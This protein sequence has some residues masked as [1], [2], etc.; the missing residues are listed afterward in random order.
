LDGFV[1]VDGRT[2]HACACT[3]LD[4]RGTFISAWG[5]RCS[6]GVCRSGATIPLGPMW[7]R[8]AAPQYR[9]ASSG[10]DLNGQWMTTTGQNKGGSGGATRV[11]VGPLHRI[12]HAAAP[13]SEGR[14][15]P[16]R[17]SWRI[18]HT[19]ATPFLQYLCNTSTTRGKKL[20]TL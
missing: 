14:I 3:A 11:L 7:V 18:F 16:K 13:D 1:S 10:R 15:M 8:L 20:T 12:A 6:L 2:D 9:D 5:S 4:V 17:E 19:D